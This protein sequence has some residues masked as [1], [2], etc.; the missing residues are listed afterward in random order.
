MKICK[1]PLKEEVNRF[2][3]KMERIPLTLRKLCPL[4][5][6][7]GDHIDVSLQMYLLQKYQSK[8]AGCAWGCLAQVC[9][10]DKHWNWKYFL[11]CAFV[12]ESM[13]I[14]VGASPTHII[15][16]FSASSLVVSF[17]SGPNQ[18][19]DHL[20]CFNYVSQNA[21]QHP[22]LGPPLV[23]F[24]Q[25]STGVHIL[26]QPLP[27]VKAQHVMWSFSLNVTGETLRDNGLNVGRQKYYV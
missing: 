24:T 7:G 12:E 26:L 3:F 8:T 18:T 25:R 16:G 20:F 10:I 6:L 13:S 14:E 15:L 9:H 11:S 1:S 21:F 19:S 27:L 17:F 2:P 5:P 23:A 4:T 22:V